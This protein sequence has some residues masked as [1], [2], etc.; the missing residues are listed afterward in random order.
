[1][2]NTIAETYGLTLEDSKITASLLQSERDRSK[3]DIEKGITFRIHATSFD[4]ENQDWAN[5]DWTKAGQRLVSTQTSEVQAERLELI[6][7]TSGVEL[8]L[9]ARLHHIKVAL[10]TELDTVDANGKTKRANAYQ[11]MERQS[12][13]F[14]GSNPLNPANVKHKDNPAHIEP[15]K[16]MED[17]LK[18]IF[19]ATRKLQARAKKLGE[20]N[21]ELAFNVVIACEILEIP[22]SVRALTSETTPAE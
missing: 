3:S 9:V 15:E 17:E 11:A 5:I 21:L 6:A 2:E 22:L 14:N 20:T 18:K 8:E 4:A 16:S 1:M 13:F 10:A 19:D 7:E 12:E